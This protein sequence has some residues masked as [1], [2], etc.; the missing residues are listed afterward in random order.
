MTL[1]NFGVIADDTGLG[2]DGTS[3]DAAFWALI[4]AAIEAVTHSATNPTVD[5]N[6]I[7]D[8]VQ[9]IKD[10]KTV[11]SWADLKAALDGVIDFTDGSLITPAS[12][13]SMDQLTH[14][15]QGVNLFIND[16]DLLWHLGDALPP[17]G[18]AIAGA[19]GTIQRCGTGLGDTNRKVGPFCSRLHYGAG[20]VHFYR[21][22]IP[23]A[24]FAQ[25]DH[26]KTQLVGGGMWVRATTASQVRFYIFDGSTQTY[27]DYHTGGGDWEWLKTDHIIS[28]AGTQLY[29]GVV[30][31]AGA[32]FYVSARD[33]RLGDHAPS[34]WSPAPTIR[35]SLFIPATGVPAVADGA[36]HYIFARPAL[37]EDIQAFWGTPA[38]GGGVLDIDIEKD[39]VGDGTWVSIFSASTTVIT[40]PAV[41]GSARPDGAYANRCFTGYSGAVPAH[42]LLRLNYDVVDGVASDTRIMI[43]ALQYTNPLEA[44]LAYDNI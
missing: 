6:D 19:G 38:G 10:A 5:A 36:F 25:I 41:A 40:D 43:R 9:A 11:G 20:D 28:G 12:V 42:A 22:I 7:I 27:S 23:A 34:R 30:G 31:S 21:F 2:Q 33:F 4:K 44:H 37:I 18:W 26:I 1:L 29:G 35:G 13:V 39:T 14:A 16:T 8:E 24:V 17:T 3:T 15:L 32:D